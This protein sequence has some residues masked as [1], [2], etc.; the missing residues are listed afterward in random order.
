MH[1]KYFVGVDTLLTCS[2]L[3]YPKQEVGGVEHV[4]GNVSENSVAKYKPRRQYPWNQTLR[5][6][7]Q[8]RAISRAELASSLEVNYSVIYEIERGR[9]KPNQAIL[10]RYGEL[11]ERR[12]RSD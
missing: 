5:N 9:Q 11:A 4:T 8:S 1:A 7:R 10:D 6:I 3:E 12:R 2:T